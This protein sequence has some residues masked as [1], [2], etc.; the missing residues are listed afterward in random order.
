MV[1]VHVLPEQGDLF[2]TACGEVAHLG[3]NAL[4]VAR[5]FAASGVG[6]DAVVAE[7]VAAAQDAYKAG[8]LRA[9]ESLR[10]NVAI[11]LGSGKFNV[12][13]LL[14]QFGLR[15]EVGQGEVS[16]GACHEVCAVVSE[17]LLLHTLCHAAQYADDE[18]APL[19]AQGVE[20]F[21]AVYDFL[22]GIV[23]HGAGVEKHGIGIVEAVRRF[24]ARHLHHGG[25]YLAVCHVHLAAVSFD[26]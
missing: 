6:H 7:V 23:A 20:D 14:P 16:V 1:T 4:H 11:G 18:F 19:A 15:H 17:Q 24:V 10:D 5:A 22:L 12:D 8:N 2:I 13:G 9:A 21:E 25:H 26:I 3:E